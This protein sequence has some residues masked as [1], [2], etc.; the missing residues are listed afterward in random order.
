MYNIISEIA[1]IRYETELEAVAVDFQGKG[2]IEKYKQALELALLLAINQ[3][4]NKWLFIKN[5]FSDLNTDQFLLFINASYQRFYRLL[6]ACKFAVYSKPQAFE[7]LLVKYACLNK[8]EEDLNLGFFK[9]KTNAYLYLSETSSTGTY[10][11]LQVSPEGYVD[12]EPEKNH[13]NDR[14]KA[15]ILR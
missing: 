12:A 5:D 15:A 13:M 4:T 2:H 14:E 3:N 7:K 9:S 8:K 10:S 6:P 11:Y 1:T